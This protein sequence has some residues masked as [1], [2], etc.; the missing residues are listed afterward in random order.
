MDEEAL[1]ILDKFMNESK[2]PVPPPPPLPME[3]AT[4]PSTANQYIVRVGDTW[5]SIA[6]SARVRTDDLIVK[7]PHVHPHYLSPGDVLKIPL[8][9]TYDAFSK[10][11]LNQDNGVATERPAAPPPQQQQARSLSGA[12]V[13]PTRG[14]PSVLGPRPAASLSGAGGDPISAIMALRGLSQAAPSMP[15]RGIS[16]AAPSMSQS[17]RGSSGSV[18]TVMSTLSVESVAV[19]RIVAGS[20]NFKSFTLYSIVP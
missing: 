20:T 2:L 13:Q 17:S 19:Y 14:T 1:N 4:T 15:P 9:I 18:A 10:M 6:K 7:N 16:Q 12:A 11:I 8:R 3:P 5:D